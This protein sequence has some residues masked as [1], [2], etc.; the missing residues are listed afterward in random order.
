MSQ[1]TRFL[2]QTLAACLVGTLML[3]AAAVA[4]NAGQQPPG[5][6]VKATH[7][8]WEIVC[9]TARPDACAMRQVSKTANGKPILVVLIEK[10]SGQKTDDGKSI[11]AAIQ[12]T[13]PLGT[14][15]RAGVAMKIDN[16]EPRGAPYD[17]CF[18][19]GCLVRQPIGEDFLAEMKA[20]KKAVVRLV[21]FPD[22]EVTAEISLSGFTKAFGA[23]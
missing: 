10:L 15:L 19:S 1:L 20:G 23:L 16:K 18:R 4:Q 2:K 11:P 22:R 6:T 17:V 13:T 9:S 7:G 21:E 12:I 5:E 8:D 3:P 14:L